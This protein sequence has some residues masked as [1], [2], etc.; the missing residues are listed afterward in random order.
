M[1]ESDLASLARKSQHAATDYSLCRGFLT[2]SLDWLW[3]RRTYRRGTLC[4]F[5][6]MRIIWG[7]STQKIPRL[8]CRMKVFPIDLAI[9]HIECWDRRR[10]EGARWQKTV[11]Q[12]KYCLR[13]F[14]RQQPV[15][16]CALRARRLDSWRSWEQAATG[17]GGSPKGLSAMHRPFGPWEWCN[18]QNTKYDREVQN[19]SEKYY[20][21][22]F[23]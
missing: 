22:L 18:F 21:E 17:N 6:K 15:L 7:A 4:C 11:Y 3:R 19:E 5:A 1:S 20:Y 2:E 23:F 16:S 9:L 10:K 12:K 8:A 14:S 13:Y